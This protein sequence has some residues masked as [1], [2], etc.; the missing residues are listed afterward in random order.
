MVDGPAIYPALPAGIPALTL[1][2]LPEY[3]S[4]SEEEEEE[5]E[6]E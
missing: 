6:E 4:T 5:E 3:V 1:T 2:G